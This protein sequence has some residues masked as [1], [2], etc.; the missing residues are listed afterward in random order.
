MKGSLVCDMAGPSYQ[1]QPL[2]CT[3]LS[4]SCTLSW[5]R[6]ARE[7]CLQQ[8]ISRL[9]VKVPPVQDAFLGC[10]HHMHGVMM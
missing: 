5:Q 4:M 6:V 1:E 9:Q 3:R 7:W 2:L 10:K 8:N